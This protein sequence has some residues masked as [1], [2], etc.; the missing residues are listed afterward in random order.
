MGK[1][2]QLTLEE[3]EQLYLWRNQGISFREI[4]RRLKKDHGGL[5]KEWQRNSRFGITYLPAKAQL[6]AERKSREQRSKAPL[7][8]MQIWLYVQEH[9]RAPYYWTPEE[10]A[11]RLSLE[12]PTL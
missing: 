2:K 3:R 1:F 4:G 6:R 11:G 9:I 5:I 10:I 8:G 12:Y 7:K